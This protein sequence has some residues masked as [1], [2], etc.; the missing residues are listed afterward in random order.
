MPHIVVYPSDMH[1][2]G[3]YR[4]ILVAQHL[5]KQG[6]DIEIVWPSNR[7]GIGGMID[8][9]TGRVVEAII[10][11][12]AD[13]IVI[14]RPT[15]TRLAQG[16]PLIRQKGVAVVV[17]M[18]D[19]LT[20]VHPANAA[21][22]NMH[23]KTRTM[24]SWQDAY[25]ACHDA[26]TVTVSADALL[27]V[28]APHGRGA[29]LPNC[30]PAAY[31]DITHPNSGVIGWGGSIHSHPDDLQVTGPAIAKLVRQGAT[32]KNVGPPA[33]IREALRLDV[34]PDA[35][36]TVP[37]DRWP[38]ELAQLGVGIAP[39]ADTKFNRSKSYLKPL[40]MAACGVPWVGSPRAEY[41]K[42]HNLGAGLLADKPRDWQ[43]HLTRLHTN[44]SLRQE[45]SQ[46]GRDVAAE[47]TV[48]HNAWRWAQV[49]NDAFKTQRQ[50]AKSA[51]V[52]V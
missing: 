7:A 35:T 36:G 47:L 26:T 37:F 45:L 40:E 2:C 49:W 44:P 5:Q 42:L 29:V 23:P 11:P 30:V 51:F 14:Q 39:L 48:E 21:F 15:H 46:A 12:G 43:R 1:G 28:Y 22:L 24:H 16:V 6:H 18:D 9:Q 8:N 34:E 41:T 3:Q 38:H 17:D 10:P 31:L 25:Q 13:V 33:G 19:D 52:K 20:C 27:K 32:F 4:L 50:A